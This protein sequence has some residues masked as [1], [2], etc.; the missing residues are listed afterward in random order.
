MEENEI[1][2]RLY[3][4]TSYGQIHGRY[5][6]ARGEKTA[7]PIV[8]LHPMPYSGIHYKT[9]APFLNA[10]RDVFALDYPGYGSS[11]SLADKPDISDFANAMIEALDNHGVAEPYDLLGFHTGCLVA[12]EMALI[13][14]D[15]VRKLVLVDV[16][17]FDKEQRESMY[18][19]VVSFD[20]IAPELSCLEE[21]WDFT[22][23]KRLEHVSLERAYE[24]FVEQIRIGNKTTWGYH[25][26]FT[27]PCE[28]KFPNVQHPSLIIASQSGLLEPSRKSAEMLPNC[29][30]TEC[31]N[32]KAMVMETGAEQI[33]KLTLDYL[34]E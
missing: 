10:G 22:V 5:L 23:S 2:K 26:A 17:Y 8:C 20:E 34:S 29:T 31:L 28:D 13:Q 18:D 14:P 32:I 1:M 16:P 7:P 4:E 6:E 30:L 19:A 9:V 33:A 11:D 27:Y 12:P 25:A 24:M 15:K 3:A 21:P